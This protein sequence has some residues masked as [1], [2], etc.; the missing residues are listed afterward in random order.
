MDQHIAASIIQRWFRSKLAK[1]ECTIS[2]SSYMSC[3]EVIL[4]K[5]SYNATEMF[6]NM[7][8]SIDVP[9]SRRQLTEQEILLIHAKY[10][11]FNRTCSYNGN[12]NY[13]DNDDD[14]DD[15]EGSSPKPPLKFILNRNSIMC[16]S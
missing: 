5:Q 16:L 15:I 9:H 11:P 8:Y 2:H 12:Y 4:D 13:N 7:K 1:K 10:D 3:Y 14:D 6:N